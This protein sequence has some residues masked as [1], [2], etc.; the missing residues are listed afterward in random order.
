MSNRRNFRSNN[1]SSGNYH[2]KPIYK[3]KEED[4][5]DLVNDVSGSKLD[6]VA[7]WPLT[8]MGIPPNARVFD[9]GDV[10]DGDYDET[11]QPAYGTLRFSNGNIYRGP[12]HYSWPQD[13]DAEDWEWEEEEQWANPYGELRF[14]DGRRFRGVFCFGKM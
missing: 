2:S 10:F 1:Y 7:V 12:I 9:N 3:Y 8:K 5:P 14:P 11:G 6:A 13:E 4:F